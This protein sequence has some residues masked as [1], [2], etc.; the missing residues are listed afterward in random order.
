MDKP[1]KLAYVGM[2]NVFL[3]GDM[4]DIPDLNFHW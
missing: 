3:S 1:D 2:A 4:S